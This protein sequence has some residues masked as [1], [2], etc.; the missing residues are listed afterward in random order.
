ML[1]VKEVEG[2]GD[3]DGVT[4]GVEHTVGVIEMLAEGVELLHSVTVLLAQKELEGVASW[5][6]EGKEV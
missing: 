3:T 6:A 1:G 5:E 2:H 4:E